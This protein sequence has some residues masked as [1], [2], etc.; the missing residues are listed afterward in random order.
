MSVGALRDAFIAGLRIVA[1]W[2]AGYEFFGVTPFFV[3][4]LYGT[5]GLVS[6]T[7]WLRE[8]NRDAS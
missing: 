2:Y 4:W 8:K 3:L 6:W 7:V 5:A 1:M